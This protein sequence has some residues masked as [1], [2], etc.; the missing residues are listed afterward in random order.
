MKFL[1]YAYLKNP[2]EAKELDADNL[3]Q[4]KTMWDA[5]RLLGFELNSLYKDPRAALT[6][7][8]VEY[9]FEGLIPLL[10]TMISTFYDGDRDTSSRNVLMNLSEHVQVFTTKLCRNSFIGKVEVKTLS[11]FVLHLMNALPGTPLSTS[12]DNLLDKYTA[13]ANHTT[14]NPALIKYVASL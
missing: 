5:I 9:V 2:S 10:D 3:F 7:E 12:I 6:D 11:N 8:Q 14:E 13:M 4:N 1:T